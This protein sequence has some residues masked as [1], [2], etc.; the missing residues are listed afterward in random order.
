MQHATLTIAC[1]SASLLLCI[2]SVLLI[3]EK[4]LELRIGVQFTPYLNWVC[5]TLEDRGFGVQDGA[6]PVCGSFVL[7]NSKLLD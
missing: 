6:L 5:H 1:L 3:P 4:N 7:R 2:K